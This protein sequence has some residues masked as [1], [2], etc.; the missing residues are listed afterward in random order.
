MKKLK[1][2]QSNLIKYFAQPLANLLLEKLK[3][4]SDTEF[5]IWYTISNYLNDY[6][7]DNNVYLD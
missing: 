1:Q 4:S 5:K 2:I 3:T 6:C 7:I